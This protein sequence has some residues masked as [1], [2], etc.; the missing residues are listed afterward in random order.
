MTQRCHPQSASTRPFTMTPVRE[1][2]RNNAVA[3]ISIA[4]AISTLAYNTWRNE[5]T[6]EQRNSRH[7]SFRILESLGDLQEI[8]DTRYYYLPFDGSQ[9]TE[10]ESRV[11]GFGTVAMIRD[12]MDLMPPPADQ[13]GL[14]LHT[15][16]LEH[17][18]ELDRLDGDG[19]HSGGAR[20]AEQELTRAI[21]QVRGAVLEVLHQLE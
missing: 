16:W 10:R 18:V 1:Q 2:I 7:A 3:L 5:T 12:L 17:F 21:N 14:E 19:K 8:V 20:L 4:I 13:K 6:E 15:L 11:R 9:S